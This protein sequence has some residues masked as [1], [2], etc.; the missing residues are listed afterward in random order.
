MSIK[1]LF[2]KN[3]VNKV[4][5]A[6]SLDTLGINAESADNVVSSRKRDERFIPP[7][8]F[9]TA[10]NFAFY[11][12]AAK[13]YDDAIK[14]V[15]LEYPYDGSESEIN[16][17]FLSSS[18][19]DEFLLNKEYPRTTGYVVLCADGW[20]SPVA[21]LRAASGFYGA[22][23][24]ASYEYIALTGGPHTDRAADESFAAAFTGSHNQ[25]N[26]YD[27]AK[28]R[29]SS[30]RLSPVT[31]ST[32]EFWL[33]KTAF[34]TTN[35]QKEVIFDIWNGNTNS[36]LA[37]YGRFM[38]EMS[39]SGP[40][41]LGQNVFLL[42]YLSGT[43]GIT[44]QSIGSTSVTTAS[45]ASDEWNH[46]AVSLVSSSDDGLVGRLYINGDVDDT[47]TFSGIPELNEITGA[48]EGQIGALRT[49]P[50]GLDTYPVRGW[51]KLS[52]S[53]DEFRYWK[54]RRTSEGIGRNWWTQVRGGTNTSDAN[55]DLGVYYKFNEGITGNSTLDSTVL[56]FSGRISNGTWTGYSATARNT[57]SAIVSA[58][59]APFEFEDP[60]IYAT[61][62]DV[63]SLKTALALSGTQHDTTNNSQLYN[64]LPAWMI[65]EDTRGD[66][67]NLTQILGSYLDTLQ[68]Q[69]QEVPK[70]KNV[71]YLSSSAKAFPFA[72][73]LVESRGLFATDVFVDA[74]I[75]ETILSRDEDRPYELD[76]EDIK[77][78]IYQNIY[79]NLVYIYKSKGTEKAF[80]NLIHCYGVGDDLVRL[81]TYAN[82]VTYEL[83]DNFRSSVLSKNV[84]DFT[85]TER[86]ESTIYQYTQSNNANSVSFISGTANAIQPALLDYIPFTLEAEVLFPSFLNLCCGVTGS[87]GDRAQFI[88]SSLFGMHSAKEE[89]PYD[90]AFPANDFA[91]LRVVAIKE[92][93]DDTSVKFK[94]TSSNTAI[95][96]LTSS[97]IA[98]VYDDTK[99]N[100]AVRFV[101]EKFPIGDFVTG[102]TTLGNNYAATTYRVE[103]YGVNTQV[104]TVQSEFYL[105]G[106]VANQNALNL[107]RS[108]KRVFAGAH[109]N[110]ITGSE[111]L[112]KS[113]IRLSSVRYWTNYIPNETIQA[114]GRD[115]EVYGAPSASLNSFVTQT[116][117]TG[118]YLPQA[119]T[120]ALNWGFYDVTSS[121]ASG[122]F[123]VADISSGSSELQTRYGWLGGIVKAQ[124][125][126]RGDFFPASSLSSLDRAYIPVAK[127]SLPEVAQSSDMVR[128][129]D[130]DDENFTRDS[131]PVDYFFSIEKSLYQVISDE[132]INMFGTIAEFN[133]LIG[134][135]INRYRQNYKLMEK[136]RNIFFEGVDNTPDLDKFIEFYKWIDSS[137]TVFLMQLIPASANASDTV[138]TL[139]ESH[140]LERNKYWSKFPTLE[141]MNIAPE[142]I[143][144][145]PAPETEVLRSPLT[146]GRAQDP[147]RH[148]GFWQEKASRED[149]PLATGNATFD[150]KR[151]ELKDAIY[152]AQK[153]VP[154]PMVRIKGK[155]Q[156]ER[157]SP[158]REIRG[159]INYASDKDRNLVY[160]AT[161]PAGP[162]AAS[163]TP[164]NV[165]LMFSEDT[166]QLQNITS[167][168]PIEL[169][170]KF[171]NYKTSFRREDE[172]GLINVNNETYTSVMKGDIAS[173]FNL[174]SSSVTTGYNNLLV[175]RFLTGSELVNL[176]SDTTAITNHIPMQGPFTQEHVGG[177]QARHIN[178][179][180]YDS[181]LTTANSIA[182]WTTR[183]EG[184][185]LLLGPVSASFGPC[186]MGFVGPDYPAASE[187]T[188]PSVV[189]KKAVYFR[190][191]R[192]KR[193]VNIRNIKHTTSSVNLGNYDQD[194]Q[195]VNTSGRS[196][197]N[198]VFVSASGAPL[199][200]LFINTL[201]ET[202]NPNSLVGVGTSIR[203]NYFS[204]N[205]SGS[206]S[207]R[208]VSDTNYSV[209]ETGD[210]AQNT[211]VFT[212]RFS[213]PG[214]PDQQ[215]L[216]FLDIAA[217]EK[218]VYSAL[219]YRNL[220]VLKSGSGEA[221][222]I[223]S[224]DQLGKR[225]GLHNLLSLHAGQFGFDPTFGS[226]PSATYITQPA[227]QK[228]NRNTLKRIEFVGATSFSDYGAT[229]TGS[230]FDNALVNFSI[231]PK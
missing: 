154:K 7:V 199:P 56:D 230:V 205:P 8:D 82:N 75:L 194:Y 37:S 74:N 231:P 210:K 35:T 105:T 155:V 91:D 201:K 173:P 143:T 57:G 163:G 2:N 174:V 208:F 103:F 96:Q 94:L 80:R 182:D 65:E 153:T 84:A 198:L 27:P 79:N 127:Q 161:F 177:R 26:I 140:I 73:H 59:A 86:F 52:A 87:E 55:T 221:D 167:S 131:R 64:M 184:W 179:N 214:G 61:H 149:A 97:Y 104:D 66:L 181:S 126:G 162:V 93:L 58:S 118:T 16:E 68:L 222:T 169:R 32:V 123:T 13:Y 109:R 121:N 137:L 111:V 202:T 20:G 114:H 147:T 195:I 5:S 129:L 24:T 158:R 168:A 113:D 192:A 112:Q 39:A 125:T 18:Y 51:G 77:N 99:W 22:P 41:D 171:Y 216:G 78:R 40:G 89:F 70:I 49:T 133:R 229:Q 48:L 148:K 9:Y 135:P 108:A 122:Q 197:N 19:V 62:P 227:F 107:I 71:Q 54:T 46:Y 190:A 145:A 76:L 144:P 36:S 29:G 90:T 53:L 28:G 72:S 178:I 220:S 14:R 43:A 146:D 23:A 176:H 157:K 92:S 185:Q 45:V 213:S 130:R 117:L 172:T 30:L 225:R 21:N 69:I 193:P 219:P 164:L 11:G 31:G 139:V 85:R 34:N 15:Y 188:Y 88:T 200:P 189:R 223:R 151:Q 110:D 116:T 101:N 180:R 102:S 44:R 175:T 33:K 4:V 166:E 215:S 226:V 138:R 170:K 217:K 12:S 132:M 141:G 136:S 160:N 124:H 1:D 100:F 187:G 142:G 183:P 211:V 204:T 98:N 150:A 206:L 203:G 128:I 186:A 212:N 3:Y 134:D 6:E 67:S 60:I 196:V 120:L 207:N 50:P 218:S 224:V 165:L 115:G 159:G 47:K 10:S 81:N 106:N 63:E 42:T 152:P 95:P 228:N 25:N 119:E 83:K 38:L 156:V 191:E 209:E 17:F